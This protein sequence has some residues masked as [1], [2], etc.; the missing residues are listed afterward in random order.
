MSKSSRIVPNRLYSSLTVT[1]RLF[2]L[3]EGARRLANKGSPNC[4]AATMGVGVSAVL[5]TAGTYRAAEFF[6]GIGLVGSALEAEGIQ[7]A[8]AND[9]D[10]VKQRLFAANFNSDI[11]HA[12]DIRQVKGSDVPAIDL[13]TASFPCTDLS[14]A[15]NR[16]GLAGEQSGM[17]WE[18]ARI[19]E[20]MGD[21]KPRAILLENVVGFFSSNGGEDM[22]AAFRRLNE[23]GYFCDLIFVDAK[24]FLPQSRPRVFI[25]GSL[26]ALRGDKKCRGGSPLRPKWFCDFA[27]HNPDL[28]TQTLALKTP[29]NEVGSLAEYVERIESGDARWWDAKK[30]TAFLATLSDINKERVERLRK[31]KTLT[32]RTTY[33]RTRNGKPV[34]EVREDA[35]SG[36]LRTAKGGSSKQ[37]IVEAGNGI[38][39]VR[40]MTA[41]EYARLQGAPKFKFGDVTESQAMFGFGDAVCVPAVR[42]IVHDYL[43]PLL[44]GDITEK[45]VEPTHEGIKRDRRHSAMPS[46]A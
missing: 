12:G 39:R 37:A 32:W 28:L 21:K 36:C 43:V 40:W 44:S 33:R 26:S 31:S 19:L 45:A 13:A 9:I 24:W 16:A 20:E 30:T 14:L 8:Y 38:V 4:Q 17:F 5:H 10:P 29:T 41:R 3:T 46:Y 22:R 1:L 15:G 7:V 23:M 18:F 34:W 27:E 25:I 42:Y 11:F 6:A 2:A 35:V